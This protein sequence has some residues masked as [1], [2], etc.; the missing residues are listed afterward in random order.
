MCAGALEM[1]AVLRCSP[2]IRYQRLTRHLSGAHWP[3]I[4]CLSELGASHA[5]TDIIT[6]PCGPGSGKT[7]PYV[8]W[9]R[10]PF[11]I[12]EWVSFSRS[13]VHTAAGRDHVLGFTMKSIHYF[14]DCL[15]VVLPRNFLWPRKTDSVT[16]VPP[17]LKLPEE[18][19][20]HCDLVLVVNSSGC[21]D[22]HMEMP[23]EIFT[24]NVLL[25]GSSATSCS[26]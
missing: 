22:L 19:R 17:L 10:F 11:K 20:L 9:A 18:I 4:S 13:Q 24:S 6:L 2:S 1:A 15:F 5:A 16:D 23:E 8:V 3:R 12:Y 14:A 25:E 26:K 21:K 7:F